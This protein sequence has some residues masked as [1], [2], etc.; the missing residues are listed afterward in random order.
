MNLVQMQFPYYHKQNWDIT[1]REY[2]WLPWQQNIFNGEMTKNYDFLEVLF[3]NIDSFL[4]VTSKHD[5][6]GNN[7]MLV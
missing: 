7:C 1:H 2:H 6:I 5:F 4:N 3:D